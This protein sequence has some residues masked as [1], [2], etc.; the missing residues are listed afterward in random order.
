[1]NTCSALECAV[2]APVRLLREQQPSNQDALTSVSWGRLGEYWG[3]VLGCILNGTL[4]L[5][6]FVCGIVVTITELH[7]SRPWKDFA[8]PSFV[9]LSQQYGIASF[10]RV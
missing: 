7:A 6:I 8:S 3:W 5:Y 10:A 4:F 2:F 1:M 9:A